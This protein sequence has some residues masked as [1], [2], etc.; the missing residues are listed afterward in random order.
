MVDPPSSP[1]VFEVC[2][3]LALPPGL[4]Q[5]HHTMG[6]QNADSFGYTKERNSRLFFNAFE[7]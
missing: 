3:P 7:D 1:V 5:P 2:T 6:N 4:V